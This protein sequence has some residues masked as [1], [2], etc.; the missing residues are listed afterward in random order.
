MFGQKF[1]KKFH[2]KGKSTFWWL[3]GKT[4]LVHIATEKL[5]LFLQSLNETLWGND[6][7]FLLLGTYLQQR[8]NKLLIT[9]QKTKQLLKAYVPCHEHLG[10]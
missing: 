4:Y 1:L 8:N 6:T 3:E 9:A 10:L 7:C 5:I 2:N